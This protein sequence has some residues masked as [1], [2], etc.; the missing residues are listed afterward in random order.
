MRFAPVALASVTLVAVLSGCSGGSPAAQPQ[1]VSSPSATAAETSTVAQWASLIAQQKAEWDEWAD[2]W[3]G[4]DCSALTAVS[5]VGLVC[6]VQLTSAMFMAQT[7]TIEHELAVTPGRKGFI[8]ATPPSE[9]TSLFSQTKTAA[10]AV[11][12][13]AEAWDAAGCSTSLGGDCT[14]LTVS[15]DRSIDALTKAFV[16]WTPYM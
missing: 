12:D 8:A 15:F 13:G 6:R 3:E 7:T 2:D 10:Q 4:N 14:S 9:V 1:A 11:A 16:G 5:K